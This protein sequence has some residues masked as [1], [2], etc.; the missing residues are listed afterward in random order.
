MGNARGLILLLG[1]LLCLVLEIAEGAYCTSYSSSSVLSSYSTSQYCP[2]GCCGSGYYEYCCTV[3]VGIIIGCVIGGLVA[4][5]VI[6]TIVCCC[7]KQQSHGGRVVYPNPGLAVVSTGAHGQ[8]AYNPYQPMP[9]QPMGGMLHQHPQPMGGMPQQPYQP[10]GGMPQQPPQNKTPNAPP[11]AYYS[12]PAY[13]AGENSNVPPN[14][15]NSSVAAAGSSS[16]P[17]A[18]SSAGQADGNNVNEKK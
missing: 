2:F 6:I 10:M 3:S 15:P 4:I 14:P 18:S 13:A 16:Q 9:Q 1:T 17:P 8:P 12:D 7:V 11:P 5:G